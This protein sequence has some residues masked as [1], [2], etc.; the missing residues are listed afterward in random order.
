[1]SHE[2]EGYVRIF[3]PH[4]GDII[5]NPFDAPSNVEELLVDKD[6]D[7]CEFMYQENI[8][9]DAYIAMNYYSDNC[10]FLQMQSSMNNLL[11]TRAIGLETST[12]TKD[13]LNFCCNSDVMIHSGKGINGLRLDDVQNV[14]IK[15]LSIYNFYDSTLIGVELCGDYDDLSCASCADNGRLLRQTQPMQMGFTENMNQAIYINAAFDATMEHINIDTIDSKT[16][17]AFD[18]FIWLACDVTLKGDINVK[19]IKSGTVLKVLDIV[20][21]IDQINSD[22]CGV[23]VYWEYGPKSKLNQLPKMEK[24][25]FG[26]VSVLSLEIVHMND[27]FK[28]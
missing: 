2:M 14:Q 1:M 23:R 28:T 22:T 20:L 17:P 18:I 7:H 27:I 4:S 13:T 3:R 9:L 6:N 11:T 15:D 8:L 26:V 25:L 21:K 5:I 19:N 24:F 16:G 10:D 12:V